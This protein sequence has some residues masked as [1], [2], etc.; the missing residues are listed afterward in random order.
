MCQVDLVF[1]ISTH[2]SVLLNDKVWENYS[3]ITDLVSYDYDVLDFKIFVKSDCYALLIN[4]EKEFKKN[5][6][7]FKKIYTRIS[8]TSWH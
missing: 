2:A 3:E 6:H 8:K 4:D 7:F 1:F 5:E